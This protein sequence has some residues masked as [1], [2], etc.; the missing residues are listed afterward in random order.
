MS[1]A[2]RL[3]CQVH[4][5]VAIVIHRGVCGLNTANDNYDQPTGGL[6]KYRMA[7]KSYLMV[8]TCLNGS[9][10]VLPRIQKIG[11]LATLSDKQRAVSEGRSF[12]I[13]NQETCRYCAPVVFTS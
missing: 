4:R 5:L 7:R 6:S 13:V 1:H 3:T 2:C 11:D 12:D 9:D 10:G 8:V